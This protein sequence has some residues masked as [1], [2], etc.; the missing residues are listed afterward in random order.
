MLLRL[1]VRLSLA[2]LLISFAAAQEQSALPL[3]RLRACDHSSH[4]HLPE[5]WRGTYLMA[6]FGKGQLV[7]ADITYDSVMP[8][9]RV[10]LLGVKG[11]LMDLLVVGKKT[12]VLASQGSAP[13]DCRDLGDT[14]WRPLPRGWLTHR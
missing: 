8:A 14:G 12:Y 11:G 9:M 10:K 6:P 7:L 13:G 1:C 5:Q 3:P 2:A 4:P